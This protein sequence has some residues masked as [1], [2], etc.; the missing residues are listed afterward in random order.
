MAG[1]PTA[2]GQIGVS[3][4]E[5]VKQPVAAGGHDIDDDLQA[6]LDQLRRE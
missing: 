6:R 2:G 5:K 3:A 1:L 4:G